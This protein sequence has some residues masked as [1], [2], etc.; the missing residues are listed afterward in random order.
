MTERRET[1]RLWAVVGATGTGKTALSLDLAEALARHGTPAEI[2]N[3][4]AMQLYRGMDIGTAKLPTAERRSIPHH[5]LDVLDV[6]DEAAV[7]W[8][9]DAA[10][11]AIREIHA[12]GADAILIGGSGLYV[13][14]VLYEFH[15]PPRDEE[16][17]TRLEAELET[18]GAGAMF[19]RLRDLDPATAARIDPRNG[20]RV[21]RALE[22]L[23][24]GSA[25]HGAALPQAPVLWHRPT[26]IIGTHVAREALVAR[27]DARVEQMWADGLLAEVTALRAR[28][29]EDGVTARRAIGYA[30]ALAQLAGD[31]DQAA[32]IAETQA[33]T[34]RYARRQVSWFKR[35]D[36]IEWVDAARPVEGILD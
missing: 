17:R 7:A 25:T 6:V 34:R 31:M 33:L 3:A 24:Q 12:R 15:F 28:G 29:L 5:L 18:G 16:V 8:Y 13:S 23:A 35:Y 4:D 1:P 19:A 32:A 20:R 27:L 10:R 2:V 30:Q 22:V 36:G 9:Q 26:R 14:S 11:T 21:V